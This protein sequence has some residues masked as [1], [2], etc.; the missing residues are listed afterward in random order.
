MKKTLK[1]I[2]IMALVVCLVLPT[3]SVVGAGEMDLYG[4]ATV[5]SFEFLT[6][7]DVLSQFHT[8]VHSVNVYYEE[9]VLQMEEMQSNHVEYDDRV[10]LEHHLLVQEREAGVSLASEQAVSM[11][12]RMGY[13]AHFVTSDTFA[14]TENLLQ[15]DLQEMGL[16]PQFSYIIVIGDVASGDAASLQVIPEFNHVW[17]GM[18]FRMRS[19]TVTSSDD[20]WMR[21]SSTSSLLPTN[22]TLTVVERV[23][24]AALDIVIGEFPIPFLGTIFALGGFGVNLRQPAA[25]DANLSIFG[26]SGWNLMITQVWSD[27]SGRWWPGSTTEWVSVDTHVAGQIWCNSNNRFIPASQVNTNRVSVSPRHHDITWRRNSAAQGYWHSTRIRDEIR[28]VT[29]RHDGV[30]RITHNRGAW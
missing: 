11:L 20:P 6:M 8:Q 9:A 4:N 13:D 22:P 29:F 24:N 21:M 25:R 12:N 26:G 28:R 10:F 1:S 16:D 3:I 17:N 7:E 30:V 18:T 23:L 2:V 19:L 15:T 27:W 5:D 14:M